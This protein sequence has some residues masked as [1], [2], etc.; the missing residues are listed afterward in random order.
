MTTIIQTLGQVDVSV[1][2]PIHPRTKKILDQYGLFSQ[3][4]SNIRIIQPLG[5][6]DMIKLMD[7]AKKILTDSGGIQKEAYMLGVPC[8]TFRENTEWVE[9]LHDTWN[10]LTGSHKEKILA[11]IRAPHPTLPQR[12]LYPAGAG[13]KIRE[14]ISSGISR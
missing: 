13:K 1:I 6:L 14:I 2:F 8:I 9:T 10:I 5:Y 3:L 12:H 4:P 7:S 11:G